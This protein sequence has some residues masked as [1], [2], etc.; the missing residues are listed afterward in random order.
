MDV[1][2]L[3]K[4]LTGD[5]LGFTWALSWGVIPPNEAVVVAKGALDNW[6]AE[7][8]TKG[9]PPYTIE[10]SETTL[11]H[12]LLHELA[13]EYKGAVQHVE[14]LEHSEESAFALLRRLRDLVDVDDEDAEAKYGAFPT[15]MSLA[16]DVANFLSDYE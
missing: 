9:I 8:R 6:T 11:R 16:N 2:M 3:N 10:I 4:A 15:L 5:F 13:A 14:A 12:I 1:G 7:L